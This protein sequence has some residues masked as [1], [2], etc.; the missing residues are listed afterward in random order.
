MKPSKSLALLVCLLTSCGGATPKIVT[1]YEPSP[2]TCVITDPPPELIGGV[3]EDFAKPGSPG[4]GEAFEVCLTRK[5]AAWV[6]ALQQWSDEQYSKC[7][8]QQP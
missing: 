1:V 2:N 6:V 7:Q 5:A 3:R 4:C 8:S